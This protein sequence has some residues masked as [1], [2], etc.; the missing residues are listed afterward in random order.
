MRNIRWP[1]PIWFGILSLVLWLLYALF[2]VS[3]TIPDWQ[4]D[5]LR[6]PQGGT[7][8]TLELRGQ[9]GDAFG[10]FNALTSTFALIGLF[11]T[12]W[13]QQKQLKEQENSS[14]TNERLTHQQQFQEQYYRAI[15]AYRS[16]LADFTLFREVTDGGP[17]SGR[18]ALWLIW[19]TQ[20]VAHLRSD[21][22]S[23]FNCAVRRQ[24]D[25]YAHE[26]LGEWNS[27]AELMT[28][29]YDLKIHLASQPSEIENLMESIGKVWQPV[30]GMY[31]YQF[32]SLFRAW[33][34]VYRILETAPIYG[35]SIESSRLYSAIYRAQLSWIEMAFLLINQSGLP[36]NPSY[37]RACHLTNL[38][39]V[40]DNLDVDSDVVVIV[41]RL[42]A[43]RH[44][45]P[46]NRDFATLDERA[47][48]S[49]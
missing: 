49:F 12:I 24:I 3:V 44:I 13:S 43:I 36:N 33:Y 9:F 39:S 20:I 22:K 7:T 45:S 40:F 41:L 4:P 18:S 28:S 46:N 10:A 1:W 6:P 8:T 48:K 25:A 42:A 26:S 19:R 14:R 47:F 38:Y 31:R 32:D 34:T 27:N 2:A 17:V 21:P 30:Y 11:F 5:I 37:P 23:I 35:I 16:L 15:D 29:I